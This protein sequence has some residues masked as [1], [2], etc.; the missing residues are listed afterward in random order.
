MF[1]AGN[2]VLESNPPPLSP[3][4]PD[5]DGLQHGGN[6][7]PTAPHSLDL[8][9][10]HDVAVPIGRNVWPILQTAR[11][12][13]G[14]CRS[15]ALPSASFAPRQDY[16]R[17]RDL[18]G[19]LPLWPAEIADDTLEGR[20]RIVQRLRRALREERRRGVAGHWTY[21][22]A[23][24]AALLQAYKHEAACLEAASP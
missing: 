20:Q 7:L 19:L 12:T 10:D 14:V 16:E 1:C 5:R 9:C 13:S 24:H 23:R 8:A 3:W 17:T 18:A 2:R 6:N 21:N 15:V 11:A 4:D 22:L